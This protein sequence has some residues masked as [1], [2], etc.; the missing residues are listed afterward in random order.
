[1][2]YCNGEQIIDNLYIGGNE[3]YEYK[4]TVKNGYEGSIFTSY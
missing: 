3:T 1:M 4:F 2:Y